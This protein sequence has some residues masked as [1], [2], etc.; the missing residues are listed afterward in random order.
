M[1]DVDTMMIS[2]FAKDRLVVDGTS[3]IASGGAVYYGGVALRRIGVRVAVVTRCILMTF[4]SSAKW[5]LRACE[6]SPH[7]RP[8]RQ[9]SRTSTLRPIWSGA[10]HVQLVPFG[11][12]GP[13]RTDWIAV[14]IE[15]E[16]T[17]ALWTEKSA[18]GETL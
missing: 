4:H 17:T 5:K 8:R 12:G 11:Y 1:Y 2:H 14:W 15:G 18:R 10:S 16:R 6:L 9:A 3:E 7:P 13:S